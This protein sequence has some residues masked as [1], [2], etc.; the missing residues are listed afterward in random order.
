MIGL[1]KRPL[2][3]SQSRWK[4]IWNALPVVRW[5]RWGART[6]ISALL[7]R[8]LEQRLNF[9]CDAGYTVVLFRCQLCLSCACST[10]RAWRQ[11]DGDCLS[12][13]ASRNSNWELVSHFFIFRPLVDAICHTLLKRSSLRHKH[14][15][16]IVMSAFL[17]AEVILTNSGLEIPHTSLCSEVQ[18]PTIKIPTNL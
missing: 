4:E 3:I 5:V 10:T 17:R 6:R 12:A 7:R 15:A 8:P 1:L 13:L 11:C 2:P 14:R 18:C 9:V 16:W